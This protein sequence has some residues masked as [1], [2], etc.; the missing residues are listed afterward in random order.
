[1]RRSLVTLG[2]VALFAAAAVV[3]RYSDPAGRPVGQSG[4]VDSERAAI[5]RVLELTLRESRSGIE[6][7]PGEAPPVP[8][9][10]LRADSSWRETSETET[11]PMTP[12]GALEQLPD[13]YSTGTYRGP[14]LRTPL[15]SVSYPILSSNP[16]WLNAGSA[17][18]AV[19]DQAMQSGRGFTFAVL[20]VRPG[21]D[22]QALNR[23]LVALGS[24][25]EASTGAYVRVRVPVEGSRLDAIAGL[26]GVLGIGAVPPSIKAEEAF[27]QEMRSRPASEQLPVYITL[28]AADPA[29]EWR[30][31]LSELGVVVGAYDRD[32]LSV[33]AN[34]PAGVLAQ[35]LAADFVLSVEP[36]PVVTVTHA[37]SVPV[38]GADGFRQ[39]DPVR[40][41]FTGI[42][43]SGVAVGVLDTGLNVSHMDIVHGRASI[44]GANFISDENWDLWLDLHG[45]GTHV[46][47]TIAGAGRENPALAGIAPGLSHLR[48]GKVLATRGSGSEVH[49]RRGMDFLSRPT[50]CFWQGAQ[51]EAVKPLIVNMSL[52]AVSLDFSGRGVGERKLDSVVHGHSQL[53]VVAQANSGLHGFS[54]YGTAKNSLAVGA[55][56]DSGIIAWFSSHGPTA[57]G[58]L[59]PSVVGTGVSITSPRGG[60]ATFGHN[61]EDGTSMAA[62][63]VAGVAALLMEARP[64]FRNRP[65]LTRARLMASAI[66]PHAFLE[67]RKQLPADN[68]DGPGAFNNLYGLGLV[69]ARTTLL[70]RDEPD[71]WL[72]GSAS[73]EPDNG[74]Y[75]Y[76]DIEVPEGAGRLDVVLTWDEQPADT[77]TRSVLNNLD[78]W[79]DRGADC[80]EDACG[81][82]A[83]RSEI[84][85]VEWLLIEDPVPGTYRIKVVPVEIYGESSTAAV[86]WKILRDEPVPQ[87]A[88]VLEDT[89]HSG[90][91]EYITVDVT[92]DANRYVASGTTLHIGCNTKFYH[93]RSV[94]SANV[95]QRNGVYREDGLHS[96]DPTVFPTKPIPIGEVAAGTPKRVQLWFLREEVPRSAVLAVTASS[97]NA[98]SAGDGIAIGEDARET[99]GEFVAPANDSF[100][101]SKWIEGAAGA[102]PLDLVLASREPGE[103]RV[104]ASSRTLWYTWEAPA[105]GLFRFRLQEADSGDP[106]DG[107]YALFTGDSV[108]DLSLEVQKSGNEISFAARAGTVYRLRI[109]SEGWDLSSMMLEWESADSR[110][111]NDDF[112]YAQVI[113]GA[114]GSIESTNE[115]A[116]LESSEFQGGAAAT[117]WY[118]WTAPEDG[119]CFFQ[120][121][122]SGMEV[123][124]FVGER[125]DELRLVSSPDASGAKFFLAKGGVTYQVAVAARSAEDSGGAFTLVWNTVSTHSASVGNDFFERA[126]QIDA[127]EGSVNEVFSG[128]V[129]PGEPPATGIGTRWWQW[130]APSDGRY[131]WRMDGNSDFRLT[132]FTGE[133]LE[134][135]QLVGSLT[136][137]SAY[138]LE[139]TGDTRYWIAAGRSPGSAGRSGHRPA[140][141]TWGPTPANDD[142][143]S[144]VAIFGTS[145]SFEAMPGY[146]T[147]APN[148]PA[149]TVGTDSVWWR[150]RAPESGWQRF[151][152]QG[153]PVSTIMSVYPDSASIRAIG[154][155]ERTFMANGRV[156]VYVLARAGQEYDIRLSSRPDVTKDQS[157]TIYWESSDAPAALGYK[158]EIRIDSLAADPL[159]G[160]FRSP[161][162]L[163][164]SDDGNYL[165][166]TAYGGVFAFLRDPERGDIALAHPGLLSPERTRSEAQLLQSAHLWW[167]ARDD[168][169]LAFTLDRHYGFALPQEGSTSLSYS[170]IDVQGGELEVNVSWDSV[171]SSPDGRYLYIANH[172]AKQL[173]AYRVDSSTLLTRVQTVAPQGAAGE[174]ALIVPAMDQPR[175]MTLSPDG[176]YLYV[177]TELG[178]LLFARDTSSGRLELVREI[179]AYGAPNGPFQD[180][181]ELRNVSLDGTGTILF[182]TGTYDGG[183]AF[184]IGFS[185]FD[186]STDPSNPVHL[187]TL[188]KFHY[189]RDLESAFLWNHLRHPFVFLDF[190]LCNLLVPHAGRTGVDVLCV[191]GYGVVV[192]N[193]VSGA[194]EVTDFAVAGWG[195]RFGNSLPD[196]FG[197]NVK[198][199]RQVGQSPDGAHIYRATSL[200]AGEYSDAIHIFER[201]SAMTPVGGG[202][203]A[204][205]QP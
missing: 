136:G 118:E 138:V 53:Y 50:S 112:A 72:I 59:S 201:A 184:E 181:N 58:R 40:E 70:S 74:S 90:Q 99:D 46:F 117:V 143:A 155:S 98:M 129:E 44:C 35:V 48:M 132:F 4:A 66:R 186:I 191:D 85:N 76:I 148:E 189:E 73:S 159:A 32:L 169:V 151:W 126:T 205:P 202:K 146:A 19:L 147:T 173:H 54:N 51:S 15:T 39:Y 97:W 5:E 115:G 63:S 108:A 65:A 188:V 145:G 175:D 86:A 45:H 89:S 14:M 174:E 110:P 123:S 168:R 6:E 144:A 156:E 101:A 62:P 158:G 133:A 172:F 157:P 116:T 111:A 193:P 20:R 161:R 13:G 167:T 55:V 196:R 3:W 49:I 122:R 140:E 137:G 170:E 56:E 12:G 1:M 153:H 64:E 96:T 94:V 179:P 83:S 171:A 185:A 114:G 37:S 81:E 47:G 124:V 77:L 176:R 165:V 95:P 29:G 177:A 87:L 60:A 17:K 195:D 84:D 204:G 25:I 43:G 8:G 80:A 42:T 187:D 141:F 142:R 199:R 163:V 92:V 105:G 30:H 154:H 113:E 182:V 11:A 91:S 198:G 100:A 93:C 107:E 127:A 38:M 128:T 120:E 106:V 149:D 131:T 150:W 22:V 152:V 178:L 27:V 109:A 28:M 75:E 61:T 180:L 166:S 68:T 160:G 34:L 79:A 16:A 194:L 36:V 23:S 103:P 121:V 33:T 41:V 21:T 2:F 52:A 69:S 18:G 139:A 104:A 203:N 200:L 164:V 125:V 78:L 82:H 192:W 162:N 71:G 67:S 24:R 134:S 88:V 183:S 190:N 102:T 7:P 57:D 135:L 119:W 10:A 197:S 31:A 26:P 9:A 130:S